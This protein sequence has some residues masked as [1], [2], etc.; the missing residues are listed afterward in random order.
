MLTEK[1]WVH[2]KIRVIKENKTTK[3]I[4]KDKFESIRPGKADSVCRA[5]N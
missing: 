3:C 5:E 4:S 2:L 1:E